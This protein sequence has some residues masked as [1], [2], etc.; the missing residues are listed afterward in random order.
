MAISQSTGFEGGWMGYFKYVRDLR[1]K[2]DPQRN[3]NWKG[4]KPSFN[5][6]YSSQMRKLKDREE[7]DLPT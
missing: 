5:Q 3:S 4:E 6:F 7:S 2:P 1:I